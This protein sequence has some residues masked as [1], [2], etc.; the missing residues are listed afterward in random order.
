MRRNSLS[1]LILP[2]NIHME[3]LVKHLPCIPPVVSVWHE[4]NVPLRQTDSNIKYL[5][6]EPIRVA[7]QD[8]Q[9]GEHCKK[10]SIRA[11]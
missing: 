8:S 5:G 4:R 9:P 11:F 7:Y 3:M 10:H 2:S 6:L 1:R